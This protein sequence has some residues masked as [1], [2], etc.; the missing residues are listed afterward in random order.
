MYFVYTSIEQRAIIIAL[1]ISL[2]NLINNFVPLKNEMFN[3]MKMF[4]E[5]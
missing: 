2:S 3:F 5:Q 1:V 4:E